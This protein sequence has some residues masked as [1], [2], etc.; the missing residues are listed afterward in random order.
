ML[1]VAGVVA[2]RS[3]AGMSETIT[4]S[5]AEVQAGGAARERALRRTSRRRSKRDRAIWTRATPPHRRRFENSD[6]HAHDVQRAD[7]RPTRANPPPKGTTVATIDNKLSSIEVRLCPGASARRPRPRATRRERRRRA[8]DERLTI[9][10]PTS[11]SSASSRR[12]RSPPRVASLATMP[13]GARLADRSSSASPSSSAWSVVMSPCAA[14]ASRSACSC[15][16]RARSAKA[17]SRAAPRAA[18]GRVQH[19]SPKR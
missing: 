14:S 12:P 1:V 15:A 4:Q 8:R 2:R 16:T 10:S 11:R 3:F 19:S 17:T 6:G 9:C 13:T 18:A 5:L 7:E